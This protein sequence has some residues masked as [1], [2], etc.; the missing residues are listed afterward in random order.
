MNGSRSYHEGDDA[1]LG[2]L[3]LEAAFD[4][5]AVADQDH[6]ASLHSVEVLLQQLHEAEIK[7]KASEPEFNLNKLTWQD[8]KADTCL[9]TLGSSS[10]YFCS[11]G[12]TVL[13]AALT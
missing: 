9:E 1:P 4:V 8:V 12:F 6:D 3:P 2:R 10:M 5:G 11:A 13:K 7:I